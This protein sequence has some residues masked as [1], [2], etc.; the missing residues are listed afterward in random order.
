MQLFTWGT[1]SHGQLGQ[2]FE[3]ELLSVPTAAHIPEELQQSI[4]YNC[5]IAGGGNHSI[6][7]SN[8][9]VWAA[10]LDNSGQICSTEK[11]SASVFS[12]IH[13]LAGCNVTSVACG[14]DFTL[15]LASNGNLYG[16]GSNTFHQLGI[17]NKVV[18][19]LINLHSLDHEPFV[20]VSAGLR[21]AA[22]VT[23]TGCL[24]IWGIEKYVKQL[25]DVTGV[26][27]ASCGQRHIVA[28]TTKNKLLA[29]GG[30]NHGQ[31]G[32]SSTTTKHI[33]E[34]LSIE[35]DE[36]NGRI[37]NVVSGWTHSLVLTD[38]QHVYSW[39]RNT[40]GQLG[41]AS[42]DNSFLP[43]RIPELEG[44]TLIAAGSEHSMALDKFGQLWTWGWN[45]HG[46]LGNGNTENQF[47]PV[48]ISHYFPGRI[49]SIGT[50]AGH[51]FAIVE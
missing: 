25:T 47:R 3:S 28:L 9:R 38:R 35:W 26:V 33:K 18:N 34:P 36:S 22:A 6:V 32:Q 2:G 21:H 1:N 42:Y 14:W 8:G 50:G 29:W 17:T 30:N 23:N 45:E 48:N 12:E 16:C 11:K 19:G 43:K 41:R 4:A 46:S 44:I 13:A 40:Y 49:Q 27:K 39:G 24:Q 5:Q 10:G 37:E 31:C 7:T 51:S 20:Q 15:F